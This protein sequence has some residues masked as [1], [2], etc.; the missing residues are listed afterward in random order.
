MGLITRAVRYYQKTLRTDEM[1]AGSWNRV[2]TCNNIRR[3]VLWETGFSWELSVLLHD[4]V[5]VLREA[6]GLFF[7][8]VV[9]LQDNSL[10]PQDNCGPSYHIGSRVLSD[11]ADMGRWEYLYVP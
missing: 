6:L 9:H 5:C 11:I 3:R 10:V 2:S 7:R 4:V 8:S 1:F